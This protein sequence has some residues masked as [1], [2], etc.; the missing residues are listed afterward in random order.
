MLCDFIVNYDAS[1][2]TP[3]SG[4]YDAG[5]NGVLRFIST[6]ATSFKVTFKAIKPGT[7]SISVAKSTAQIGSM[8][9]DYMNVVTSSGSI[10]ITAPQSY[11]TDN[12]LSSLEISPE[13]FLRH[14]HQMLQLIRHLWEAIVK[15]L[16]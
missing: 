9:E 6:D 12:T 3:V 13:C 4:S 11:S 7:A 16:Q 14:F 8:T 10:T 5:G 15:N 1:M 2:I